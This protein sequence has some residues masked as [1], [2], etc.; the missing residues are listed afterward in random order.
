MRYA[1][2]GDS[3][4]QVLW[5][6]VSAALKKA[7]HE[8]VLTR[9]QPGWSAASYQKEGKLLAQLAAARPDV[10]VFNVANN[11]QDRDSGRYASRVAWAV[12]AARAAGARAIYWQGPTHATRADVAAYHDATAAMEP[13]IV[14][15]AGAS[16]VDSRPYTQTGHRDGV[17]FDNTTY[18]RWASAIAEGLLSQAPSAAP[19][20]SGVAVAAG[21]A[22]QKRRTSTQSTALALLALLGLVG[23]GIVIARQR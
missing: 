5:P 19:S 14:A 7:G 11:N 20:V 13:G 10:V 18:R 4:T 16:W 12:D 3:H 17:H 1:L 21:A 8:V 9:A 2:I 6:L 22:I 15:Q 23:V